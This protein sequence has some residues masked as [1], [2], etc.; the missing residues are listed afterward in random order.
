MIMQRQLL[1]TG[2]TSK[3]KKGRWDGSVWYLDE[4]GERKR[5]SFSGKTQTEVQERIKEYIFR[6][7]QEVQ[8]SANTSNLAFKEGMQHWLEVFKYP[9]LQRTSYDRYE[10]TA[11]YQ[12]YP[13]IGDKPIGNIT[14]ADLKIVL[15][16]IM[17]SGKSYSTCKKAYLLLSEYFRYLEREDL[18]EKNPMRNVEMI[19]KANYLSAQGIENKPQNELVTAF[20]PEE[21]E[22][23]KAEAFK[24]F[25]NGKPLYK[26]SAVYFLMLNTGLRR[27]E[28]CGLLNSD[29]DLEHR[30]LHVRRAVKEYYRRD[31]MERAKGQETKVGPPKSA[32]SVRDVPLNDTAIEMINRLR[33][34]VYLGEDT[35]LIPNEKGE[36]IKPINLLRRFYR[37]QT[38]AGIP[39]EDLKGL[40]A[41]RHTFATTLINGIKQ[42]DGTIKSLTV[43]QV[44]DLLGHTT[45]EITELYY[46]KKD[47]T[48]LEGLTDAFNL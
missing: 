31:G 10:V 33:K 37:L 5:K 19:K 28:V 20:S 21:I 41:L 2:T 25:G 42:P 29:I 16:E 26:Q 27:G 34:E 8:S 46:V 43:K 45:T 9:S 14:A 48:K 18:I 6:F 40:H 11:K 15:N 47:N 1:T 36:F 32:T 44:A 35:P 17:L 24:R 38:A 22:L 13:F 12:I 30:V 3:N 23:L 4:F 39:E 7:N